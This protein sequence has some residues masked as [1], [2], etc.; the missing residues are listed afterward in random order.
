MHRLDIDLLGVYPTTTQLRSGHQ[1]S[2]SDLNSDRS[3]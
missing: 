2:P 1:P 3:P